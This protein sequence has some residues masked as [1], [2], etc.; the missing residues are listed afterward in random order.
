MADVSQ[1]SLLR[2]ETVAGHYTQLN[3]HVYTYVY[4]Y[5]SSNYFA[6]YTHRVK[7][8]HNKWCTSHINS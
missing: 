6:L 4:M 3:V 7:L 2:V 5:A 8:T 1:N